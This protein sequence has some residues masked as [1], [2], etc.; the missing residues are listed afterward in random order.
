M[1]TFTHIDEANR[2]AMVNVGGKAMTHRTA[3]ARAVVRLPEDVLR[4]LEG[5]EIRAPKGPVMQTASLAGI[6]AAKKTSELIPLCHP[7]GLDDCSVDIAVDENHRVVIDCRCE[8][9][10]KTGVEMEAMTGATV[11]ALTIYDMCKG[12]SR[13]IVIEGVRLLEKTG[14]KSGTFAAPEESF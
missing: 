12:L 1:N 6:M 11:A 3:R 13:D 10:H 14:G 9:R 8:V 7:I 4:L 5:D 2:P